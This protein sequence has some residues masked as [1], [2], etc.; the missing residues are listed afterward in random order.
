MVVHCSQH[1]ASMAR[2]RLSCRRHVAAPGALAVFADTPP[3]AGSLFR[4]RRRRHRCCNVMLTAARHMQRRQQATATVRL[5]AMPT[6]YPRCSSLFAIRQQLPCSPRVHA[7]ARVRAPGMPPPH[8]TRAAYA[9]RARH[10]YCCVQ[11]PPSHAKCHHAALRPAVRCHRRRRLRSLSRPAHA[12]PPA[13]TSR[14]GGC[15]LLRGACRAPT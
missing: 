12:M 6:I 2:R 1:A 3:Y 5:R 7:A 11:C 4:R 14:N 13:A 8:A 15:R 10:R 9:R